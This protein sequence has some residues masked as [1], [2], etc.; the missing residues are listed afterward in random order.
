MSNKHVMVE[1]H[2]DDTIDHR[3]L[4]AESGLESHDVWNEMVDRLLRERKRDD[5]A[6][7][8]GCGDMSRGRHHIPDSVYY[9]SEILDLDCIDWEKLPL[10]AVWSEAIGGA[11]YRRES[12]VSKDAT[13]AYRM[14]AVRGRGVAEH[15]HLV[16]C[17]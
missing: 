10:G 16:E 13:C 1:R 6:R 15:A 12:A 11:W 3:M 2:F 9:R 5:Y 14:I 7:W 8:H 17:P 4:K